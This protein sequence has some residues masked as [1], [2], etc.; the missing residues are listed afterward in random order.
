M[1]LR[2]T[3]YV[4]YIIQGIWR[5]MRFLLVHVIEMHMECIVWWDNTTARFVSSALLSMRFD[6]GSESQRVLHILYCH[7]IVM[8]FTWLWKIN[9]Y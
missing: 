7:S 5:V 9:N 6:D 4:P 1:R 2:G 3:R 8:N